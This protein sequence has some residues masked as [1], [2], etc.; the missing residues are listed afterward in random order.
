[1]IKVFVTR[2]AIILG[3]SQL[4][5]PAVAQSTE[6]IELIKNAPPAP[7]VHELPYEDRKKVEICEVTL[8]DTILIKEINVLIKEE[9]IGSEMFAKGQGY[10]QV[11][12]T[13]DFLHHDGIPV[14]N[15]IRCYYINVNYT[16]LKSLKRDKNAYAFYPDFY[17]FVGGRL[18]FIKAFILNDMT[19]QAFTEKSMRRLRKIQN[20]FLEKTKRVTAYDKEGRKVFTDRHFRIDYHKL[21][22]GKYIY[23]YLDGSYEVKPDPYKIN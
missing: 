16:G 22:G 2:V 7:Y 4:V 17:S 20:K 13:T 19:W 14:K 6:L 18:I 11:F 21:H 12:P 5:N 10:I 8:R 23:I 1:M 15:V 3:F 9:T